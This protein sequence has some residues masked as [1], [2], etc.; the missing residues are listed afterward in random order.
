[1]L[2]ARLT[3]P[4]EGQGP[5]SSGGAAARGR[6]WTNRRAVIC[7]ATLLGFA[8]PATAYLWMIHAYGVNVIYADQWDDVNLVGHAYS[9][10]LHLSTLWAQHYENRILFPN[11]IVLA[12]AY[13]THLNVV[14]E[15]Y[16]SALMVF[17][18]T[19]LVIWAHKL[20]SPARPL[21]W[22]C[23]VAFLFLSLA[24]AGNA[25]WGFQMAWY[26]VLLMITL[27]LFLLD[28]RVQAPLVMGGAVAAGVVASFSSLQGLLVWPA[29]LVIIYLRRRPRAHVLVWTGMAVV[30]AV[31]Y[32]V[33]FKF[34]VSQPGSS[35]TAVTFFLRV[36]G[37][38]VGETRPGAAE[39]LFGVLLV[40]TAVWSFWCFARERSAAGG[41]PLGL[42]L[43]A[44]GLLFAVLTTYGRS[45][46]GVG[47]YEYRYTVFA[48]LV[49]IGL[50]LVMLDRPD[51]TRSPLGVPRLRSAPTGRLARRSSDVGFATARV[52]VGLG[53]AATVVVGTA[54]GIAEARSIHKNR[55]Y[56]GRVTVRVN[57]Y[58]SP[59][60]SALDWLET[61]TSIRHRVA[62]ARSHHL[63]L[64]GTGDAARYL[65]EKPLD[66][67]ASP[68]RAAVAL[69]PGGSTV[70]GQRLLHVVVS[71][72]FD[73]TRVDYLLSGPGVTDVHLAT[74]TRTRY[75]W[76]AAWN[77]ATVQDGTYTIEA[78][79]RDS[80]G[81]TVRTAPLEVRVDNQ[82]G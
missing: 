1:M 14:T 54:N 3:T 65:R 15:E 20:R 25:L 75:G 82:G 40:L 70:R 63:S 45:G 42:A 27:A 50:Y 47:T 76:L 41:R 52:I 71:D 60:V 22:Y 28:R 16:L 11:L 77:T 32:F 5:P 79:V 37:D 19:A 66:L 33:G 55:L 4:D 51:Q 26:L 46:L 21:I 8:L 56:L 58:P 36:I 35:G 30:T 59:V 23:P 31:T 44:C 69:I 2:E 64:F 81:R 48:V 78:V 53:V 67:Y 34:D 6:R 17:A 12:L 10:T 80:G 74:A 7:L 24:Q 62:I 38:V 43:V 49:L 29:G 61:P 68:L 18:A 13:T 73:V 39:V 57:Q 72:R 9:G